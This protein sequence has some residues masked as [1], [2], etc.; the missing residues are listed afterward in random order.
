MFL[1]QIKHYDLPESAKSETLLP[2][3]TRN[4][5]NMSDVFCSIKRQRMTVIGKQCRL[6]KGHS[7]PGNQRWSF[8]TIALVIGS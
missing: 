7:S 4:F 1:R 3:N 2:Q 5:Q 8:V 6:T